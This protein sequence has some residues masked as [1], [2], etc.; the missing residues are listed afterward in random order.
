MFKDNLL[1]FNQTTS[2]F[3]S[4]LIVS[5]VSSKYSPDI[6]TLVSSANNKE[7]SIFE[8]LAISLTS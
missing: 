1:A 7:N 2:F 4:V 3:S 8:T 5:V 6:N